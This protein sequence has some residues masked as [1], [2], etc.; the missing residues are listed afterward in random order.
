MPDSSRGPRRSAAPTAPP[1]A[2][3]AARRSDGCAC[4]WSRRRRPSTTASFPTRGDA[5]AAA[6]AVALDGE[7]AWIEEH[8]AERDAGAP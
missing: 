7:V 3:R 8:P 2:M 5:L 4:A 1:R 6:A